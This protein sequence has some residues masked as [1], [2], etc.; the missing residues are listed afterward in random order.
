MELNKIRY[1]LY[2]YLIK[3]TFDYNNNKDYLVLWKYTL[4][5]LFIFITFIIC[6]HYKQLD[7]YG[8]FI[9]ILMILFIY[10]IYFEMDT[11]LNKI[12]IDKILLDYKNYYE[13]SNIIFIENFDFTLEDETNNINYQKNKK[14]KTGGDLILNNDVLNSFLQEINKITNEAYIKIDDIDNQHY[15]FTKVQ[16]QLSLELKEFDKAGLNTIL[17]IN[18]V[19]NKDTIIYN[20]LYYNQN[21][22]KEKYAIIKYYDEQDYLRIKLDWNNDSHKM[23]VKL[24][25]YF[26]PNAFYEIISQSPTINYLKFTNIRNNLLNF[27]INLISSDIRNILKN[28]LIFNNLSLETDKLKI[29]TINNK[30]YIFLNFNLNYLSK[31][32]RNNYL[33]SILH[34]T[35]FTT[36][37][38]V[39]TIM[40]R[41]L[42]GKNNLL[43][44]I[45]DSFGEIPSTIK[46]F[47]NILG[48][49]NVSNK[50]NIMNNYQ[51]QI[52]TNNN[53]NEI[54]NVLDLNLNIKVFIEINNNQLNLF[55]LSQKN[56]IL[57]NL[58]NGFLKYYENFVI[59]EKN[60]VNISNYNNITNF[61]LI[62]YD[63]LIENKNN[64]YI[65]V[66]LQEIL[67]QNNSYSKLYNNRI[68]Y[69]SENTITISEEEKTQVL[70]EILD[71]SNIFDNN[72]LLFQNL[73][74]N[75]NDDNKL[76]SIFNYNNN[77][78]LTIKL[79]FNFDIFKDFISSNSF[80]LTKYEN[81]NT[82]TNEIYFKINDITIFN[83]NTNK[84]FIDK[85]D[86]FKDMIT[87]NG[88]IS[89]TKTNYNIIIKDIPKVEGSKAFNRFLI[90]TFNIKYLTSEQKK[91]Y[92]TKL[93]NSG[94]IITTYI[95]PNIDNS[96]RVLIFMLTNTYD[97]SI[98]IYYYSFFGNQIIETNIKEFNK[99]E[100]TKDTYN[101]VISNLN[102]NYTIKL[103][104]QIPPYNNIN[105]DLN[106]N[107]FIETFIGSTSSTD[108]I[109]NYY[110]IINNNI[111]LLSILLE[112]FLDYFTNSYIYD[113]ILTLPS[114]QKKYLLLDINEVKRHKDENNINNILSVILSSEKINTEKKE[115][116]TNYQNDDNLKT[117]I[118]DINL[119]IKINNSQLNNDFLNKFAY[120]N[121]HI[122]KLIRKINENM[123]IDKK[124][125]RFMEQLNIDP[126]DIILFEFLSKYLNI[127]QKIKRSIKYISDK[128]DDEINNES[129]I[130]LIN[131]R[132]ILKYIDIYNDTD[133]LYIKDYLFIRSDNNNDGFYKYLK[134]YNSNETIITT[135]KEN[136]ELLM[137]SL[138]RKINFPNNPDIYNY[139]L[140]N[141][142]YISKVKDIHKFDFIKDF[143]K[144]L[145][146][147][148]E[149]DIKNIDILYNPIN[150]N[151]YF[152]KLIETFNY[153]YIKIIIISITLISII[154]H[155]FYIDYIRYFR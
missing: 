151:K 150:Q 142:N 37:R 93:I 53:I 41:N 131:D 76:Y 47:L 113:N 45:N 60:I 69:Y 115:I 96:K 43:F 133:Y 30:K 143:L 11:Y 1:N 71:I 124:T 3:D 117:N 105:S 2:N 116:I 108:I 134:E 145:N 81:I 9:I 94:Q 88:L 103:L 56:T 97:S 28:D 58:I 68:N 7:L 127:K 18:D 26:Q 106:Y 65:S 20:N 67:N 123:I 77:D 99:I 34:N 87:L 126:S 86:Y 8:I 137:T 136:P 16:N 125:N 52:I 132:S 19:L 62:K 138:I 33:I 32:E 40:N 140:I 13:L 57:I 122:E 66:I 61:F 39:N 129:Y 98:P 5:I 109:D 15:L 36:Y 27:D 101:E 110:F 48:L 35:F 55:N 25:Y 54:I 64:K 149:T 44:I 92:L 21:F 50:D 100:I 12:E 130:Q 135:D 31:F 89:L 91:I 38:D 146:N 104:I 78:Y 51:N 119:F 118:S 46:L 83:N 155:A 139:Y 154:F 23:L 90:L 144:Y 82:Y 70:N 75:K 153:I 22:F 128:T 49:Q 141:L 17:T 73:K 74:N 29:Q 4:I 85:R 147:K 84:I 6:S 72:T 111:P 63:E 10:I 79:D 80:N 42:F 148:Y 14:F 120:I 24:N 114:T 152:L 102:L 121:F 107:N 112:G 59:K 95:D